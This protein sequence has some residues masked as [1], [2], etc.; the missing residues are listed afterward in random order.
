[1]APSEKALLQALKKAT[2]DIWK[3]DERDKLSVKLV[4]TRVESQNNLDEGFFK[5]P[6]W[7]DKSKKIIEEEAVSH[8]KSF[9]L[10][11]ANFAGPRDD[12]AI[13]RNKA[14]MLHLLNHLP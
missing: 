1:M 6:A 8:S 2:A 4:R 13:S 3:T 14:K 5:A 11:I 10:A 7:K 12:S 9:M